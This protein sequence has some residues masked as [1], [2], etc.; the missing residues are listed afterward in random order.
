MIL[1]DGKRRKMFKQNRKNLVVSKVKSWTLPSDDEFLSLPI[2]ELL[3]RLNTSLS[4]L[5]SEEAEE[6]LRIFG[7]NELAK[8]RKRAAIVE[9]LSH[10]RSPLVIILLIAGLISGFFGETIN[11][12][13]IFSIV[14]LSVILD[15]YQNN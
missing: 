4:G 2:D 7:F 12:L 15:F 1:G 9:F 3:A 10:F 14:L 13:I 8:R 11:A 6:R 5:S